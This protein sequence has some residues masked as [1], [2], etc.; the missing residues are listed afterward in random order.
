MKH[1]LIPK[2]IGALLLCLT[3]LAGLLP[4]AAWA[5]DADKAIMLGTGNISGYDSTNV[6]D[7]IYYGKWSNSPIKWRVLDDQT[8]F[9]SDSDGT[10]DAGLFLLSDGLLRCV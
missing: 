4:T 2:R 9:D 3:L 7:Y 8:N 1:K 10:N 6:Y 5:A